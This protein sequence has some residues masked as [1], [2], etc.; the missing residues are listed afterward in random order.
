[1]L[2]LAFGRDLPEA[3]KFVSATKSGDAVT[4]TFSHGGGLHMKEG[5]TGLEIRVGGKWTAVDAGR[6]TVFDG[7]L[8]V[9]GAAEATALRYAWASWPTVSLFNGAGLPAEPFMAEFG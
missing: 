9:S 2:N 4:V 7:G 5:A 1:M 8:T 3:A 6:V